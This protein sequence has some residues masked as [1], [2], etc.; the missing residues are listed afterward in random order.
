MYDGD[1]TISESMKQINGKVHL[2]HAEDF[3]KQK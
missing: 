2:K 3:M 1:I